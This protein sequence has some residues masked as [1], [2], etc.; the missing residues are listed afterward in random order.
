M[1]AGEKPDAPCRSLVTSLYPVVWVKLL[2][3][4]SSLSSSLHWTHQQP[5]RVHVTVTDMATKSAGH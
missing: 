5:G 4:V 2:L 1:D 3:R